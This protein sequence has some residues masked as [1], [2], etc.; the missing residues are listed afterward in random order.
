MKF[1][2]I[3]ALNFSKDYEWLKKPYQ[4]LKRLF[5]QVQCPS[6]LKLVKKSQLH[7]IFSTH[8]SVLGYPDELKYII[9]NVI[10]F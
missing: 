2:E 1:C 5:H 3:F 9:L 10:V 7:L 6:T 4:N 8:F